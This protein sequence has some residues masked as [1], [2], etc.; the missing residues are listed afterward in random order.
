MGTFCGTFLILTF[1]CDDLWI[2]FLGT[3][4][5]I[6]NV[7]MR[8]YCELYI[9]FLGTFWNISYFNCCWWFECLNLLLWE[10]EPLGEKTYWKFPAKSSI[11]FLGI[12]RFFTIFWLGRSLVFMWGNALK[13]GHYQ[14]QVHAQLLPHAAPSSCD[15]LDL[16][17]LPYT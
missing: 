6:F 2:L 4:S 9:H 1:Y 11:F 17:P 15:A 16:R 14:K 7:N 8:F 13:Q 12:F 10:I 3:L 5:N